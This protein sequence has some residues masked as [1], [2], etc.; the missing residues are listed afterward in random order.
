MSVGASRAFLRR[1][2]LHYLT[3]NLSNWPIIGISLCGE[4]VGGIVG[5]KEAQA[6]HGGMSAGDRRTV[7][8]AFIRD[9]IQVSQSLHSTV[10]T[11][12]DVND[13]I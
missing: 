6:Y 10:V 1:A 8:H 4:Q 9:E 7:H 11:L 12:S 2:L 13:Q 3:V 5:L